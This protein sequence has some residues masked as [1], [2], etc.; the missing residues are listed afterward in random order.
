MARTLAASHGL[1]RTCGSRGDPLSSLALEQSR[2]SVHLHKQ[3]SEKLGCN[4]GNM[5][6]CYGGSLTSLRRVLHCSPYNP[7]LHGIVARALR[8][9]VSHRLKHLQ[10]QLPLPSLACVELP[11]V[12][13]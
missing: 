4:S 9:V 3:R 12:Q 11:W 7:K 10:R 5:E 2:H 1:C 6:C 8:L 13:V